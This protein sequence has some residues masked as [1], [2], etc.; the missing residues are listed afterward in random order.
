MVT[1]V[2]PEHDTPI[3]NHFLEDSAH[4]SVKV[5]L[6]LLKGF[7]VKANALKAIKSARVPGKYFFIQIKIRLNAYSFA[8]FQHTPVVNGKV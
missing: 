8:G 1:S 2:C 5:D 6:L 4:G 7:S 3:M